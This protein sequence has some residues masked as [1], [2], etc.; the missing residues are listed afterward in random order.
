[1]EPSEQQPVRTS[2]TRSERGAEKYPHVQ[3]VHQTEITGPERQFITTRK[4]FTI[5]DKDY[6]S[7]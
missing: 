5:F 7:A 6:F 2:G 1:V 4:Y 3:G